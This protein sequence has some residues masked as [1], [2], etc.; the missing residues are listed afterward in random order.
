MEL[1]EI[2]AE[3]ENYTGTFPRLALERSIA[4]VM[5]SAMLAPLQLKQQIDYLR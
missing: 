5:E 4:V 1:I 2:I 3:L